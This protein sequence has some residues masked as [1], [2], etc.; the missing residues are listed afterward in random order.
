[1]TDRVVIA[2]GMVIVCVMGFWFGIAMGVADFA[3]MCDKG[4]EYK[5]HHPFLQ[6]IS[7]ECKRKI[8][9]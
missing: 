9:A 5:I 3:M 1:M 8:N 2:I 6:S 7:F 4:G